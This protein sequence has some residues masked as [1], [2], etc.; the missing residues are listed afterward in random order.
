MNPK[1]DKERHTDMLIEYLFSEDGD[2]FDEILCSDNTY[3]MLSDENCI[4]L[5]T[6]RMVETEN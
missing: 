1:T 4:M 5:I 6:K 3:K 2:I